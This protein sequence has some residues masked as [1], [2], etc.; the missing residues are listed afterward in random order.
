MFYEYVVWMTTDLGER[1]RAKSVSVDTVIYILSQ[2]C[3]G[4][5]QTKRGKIEE[6]PQISLLDSVAALE[7]FRKRK[8]GGSDLFLLK[9]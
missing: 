8:V 3:I 1:Y 6:T 9:R 5:L 2:N 7:K 4:G